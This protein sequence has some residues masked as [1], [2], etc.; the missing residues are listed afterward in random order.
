MVIL[1]NQ[2]YENR[3]R[4]AEELRSVFSESFEKKDNEPWL[5]FSASVGISD[6]SKGDNSFEQVFKRADEAMYEDK[7]IFKSM[8]GSYR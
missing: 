5:R 2:D 7:K 8:H 1:Q 3:N 6:F 4:L